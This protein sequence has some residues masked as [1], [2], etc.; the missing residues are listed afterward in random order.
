MSERPTQNPEED[1]MT[2]EKDRKIGKV[3][4]ALREVRAPRAGR[5]RTDGRFD[6]PVVAERT[7]SEVVRRL[8]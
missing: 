4:A 7:R 6:L 8:V 2:S 5:E 1:V 3:H